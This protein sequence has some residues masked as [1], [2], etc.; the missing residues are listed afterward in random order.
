MDESTGQNGAPTS[1]RR[2]REDELSVLDT[3]LVL[4]RN[5]PLILRTAAVV[6]LLGLSYAILKSPEFTST[7]EVVRETETEAPNLGG[8]LSALQGLGV[9]LG[10][11]T[12]SGLSPDAYPSILESREVRLGVV[13]D[14]FSFPDA[15]R[16]MTY[17]DYVN[18][19][20]GLFG[21][22]LDYTIRLPRTISEATSS[23]SPRP[24][25]TDS[26]GAPLYPTEDEDK[27]LK[28]IADQVAA[29]VDQESGLMRIAVTAEESVL[30]ADIAESFIRHLRQRVR[31][32]RTQK[33]KENLSFVEQRFAE[34]QQELETAEERLAQ[35]LERNQSI[36]SAQLQFQQDRLQRQVRFKEEL[37]SELQTQLTQ[38]RLDLQRQQP[39]VTVVERPVPPMER[40]APRRT[41]VVLFSLV[42]GI[43]LG[44]GLAFARS[45]FTNQQDDAEEREKIEEI[46][47][48]FVPQ[49]LLRRIRERMGA[50]DP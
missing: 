2:W 13:R 6:L 9:S 28:M 10:S 18:R 30:A 24:A 48:A 27:A 23:E 17:V 43:F 22:L 16:R 40:S 34:V 32:I 37:Y 3:L 33:V 14:T 38:T 20:P 39:V 41:L 12:G 4:A 49:N 46:R 7:A 19:D 45:F 8:G 21:L 11:L 1:N 50:T 42:F 31:E 36:T 44:V 15:E 29:S 25:G 5:K 35:F 26:T 47:D